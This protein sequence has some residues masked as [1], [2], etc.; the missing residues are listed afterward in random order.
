MEAPVL[1]PATHSAVRSRRNRE[2]GLRPRRS[3]HQLLLNRQAFD[4]LMAD[5]GL[6]GAIEIAAYLEVGVGTIYNASRGKP[7]SDGFVSA[8]MKKLRSREHRLQ[9][10]LI[11]TE[12]A[13]GDGTDEAV[14]A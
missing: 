4:E 10:F 12:A 13:P 9:D 7:I 3:K 5:R 11:P 8:L 2:L 6:R 1:V 14:A